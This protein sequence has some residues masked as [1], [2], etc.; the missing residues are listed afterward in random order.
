[1]CLQVSLPPDHSYT[2][3]PNTTVRKVFSK[4]QELQLS[5]YLTI[6]SKMQYGLSTIQ[7]KK[8]TYVYSAGLGV[9]LPDNWHTNKQAG[10]EC[11]LS[12]RAPEA[13]SLECS[14]SFNVHNIKQYFENVGE[15]YK[16]HNFQLDRI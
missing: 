13:T 6:L 12:N 7:T 16:R 11:L 2:Y 1:M 10:R 4:D 5:E 14:T 3:T 9:E 15:V 8:L